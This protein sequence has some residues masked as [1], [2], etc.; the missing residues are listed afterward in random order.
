MEGT[1]QFICL[2]RGSFNSRFVTGTLHQDLFVCWG[3]ITDNSEIMFFLD[4]TVSK[5]RRLKDLLREKKDLL[6]VWHYWTF[7]G[8]P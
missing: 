1:E 7:V 2:S 6:P 5:L 4:E 8:I 3:C